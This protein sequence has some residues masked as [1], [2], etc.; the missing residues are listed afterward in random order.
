MKTLR[1]LRF[2]VIAAAVAVFFTSCGR[3]A[4]GGS[5]QAS[6][7]N[8]QGRRPYASDNVIRQRVQNYIGSLDVGRIARLRLSHDASPN[9][10][11]NPYVPFYKRRTPLF[12]IGTAV[13]TIEQALRDYGQVII[14]DPQSR[15][16]SQITFNAE[17]G[18]LEWHRTLGD[19]GR[20]F[21]LYELDRNIH[22]LHKHMW[23]PYW[24]DSPQQKPAPLPTRSLPHEG[25]V[26]IL[27]EGSD[28][29]AHMLGAQRDGV[30]KFW[31][32]RHGQPDVFIQLE[33]GNNA[34]VAR[35]A[36]QEETDA[37]DRTLQGYDTARTKWGEGTA[38][39]IWGGRIHLRPVDGRVQPPTLAEHPRFD[40]DADRQQLIEALNWRNKYRLDGSDGQ[41]YKATVQTRSPLQI[42]IEQLTSE[43]RRRGP[44]S[45]FFRRLR[46]PRA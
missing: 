13:P 34:L 37:I 5:G 45:S 2:S 1:L 25:N 36:R 10:H 46:L 40:T 43:G 28:T 33:R 35:K 19:T 9:R 3:A 30:W 41:S 38:G 24:P 26:P 11:P 12:E 39:I 14:L 29:L 4:S 42:E 6:S 17:A 31:H 8:S 27:R 20:M 21:D 23:L 44:I 22:I 15:T 16:G 32:R 18:S 7:S